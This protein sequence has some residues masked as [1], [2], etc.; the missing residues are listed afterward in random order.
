MLSLYLPTGKERP[1]Q[2][3]FF[4]VSKSAKKFVKFLEKIF[5]RKFLQ[6][7]SNQ[8]LEPPPPPL[9]AYIAYTSLTLCSLVLGKPIR[10]R[11]F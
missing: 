7:S 8:S 6:A 5:M 11:I 3:S 1:I 4:V 9:P 2:F 10:A